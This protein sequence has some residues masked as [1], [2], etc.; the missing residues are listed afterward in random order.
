[1][2]SVRKGVNGAY[3]GNKKFY[4][5]ISTKGLPIVYSG[6]EKIIFFVGAQPGDKH[7]LQTNG[8]FLC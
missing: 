8:V 2:Y 6:Q 4:N 1:M 3:G 5:N 7:F